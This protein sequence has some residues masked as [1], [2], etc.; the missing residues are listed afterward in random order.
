[1]ELASVKQHREGNEVKGGGA[2]AGEPGG[3]GVGGGRGRGRG[4]R[5]GGKGEYEAREER[6]VS[7]SAQ[8]P[9]IQ[10]ILTGFSSKVSN[11]RGEI[12]RRVSTVKRRSRHG[13]PSF[14]ETLR[15]R[16][17]RAHSRMFDT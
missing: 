16:T 12:Y 6:S 13:E 8:K 7:V 2:V 3:R 10:S 14:H 4:A 11:L 15:T 5:E 9:A 1:M 17:V